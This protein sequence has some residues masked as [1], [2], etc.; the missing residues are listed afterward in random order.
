[1]H[2]AHASPAGRLEASACAQHGNRSTSWPQQHVSHIAGMPR[3]DD[4]LA[5]LRAALLSRLGDMPG[6]LLTMTMPLVGTAALPSGSNPLSEG[7]VCSD[8]EMWPCADGEGS[9]PAR[10]ALSSGS[11]DSS[12]MSACRT[13][14]MFVCPS[15][16][17]QAHSGTEDSC[18]PREQSHRCG[19][20]SGHLTALTRPPASTGRCWSR[21]PRSRTR[22][23]PSSPSQG[24]ISRSTAV[25]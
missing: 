17:W 22:V 3:R 19:G 14:C 16:Q 8:G 25:V 15:R 11:L 10:S 6:A 13:R 12:V 5:C 4:A 9:F 7:D 21:S 20:A 24:S 1:M 18:M 2:E 23:E